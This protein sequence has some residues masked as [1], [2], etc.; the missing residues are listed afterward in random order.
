MEKKLSTP[1]TEGPAT[2]EQILDLAMKIKEERG[3]SLVDAME[4]AAKKLS[5]KPAIR[6]SFNVQLEVKQKVGRWI[7]ESFGGHP[8][9]SIE[10]RLAVYIAQTLNQ[11]RVQSI[12]D[13]EM[14]S[15]IPKGS[16]ITVRAD[17]MKQ[18]L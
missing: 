9:L 10:D 4:M 5:P 18:L 11:K 12:R 3:I 2:D 13:N 8:T 17:K 15:E 7:C 14:P 16:A 6:T 1:E